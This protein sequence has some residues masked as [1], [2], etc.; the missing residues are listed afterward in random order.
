MKTSTRKPYVSPNLVVKGRVADVTQW[1]PCNKDLGAGD[2][3]TFQQSPIHC[4]S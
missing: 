4:T 3:F 1:T 2:G